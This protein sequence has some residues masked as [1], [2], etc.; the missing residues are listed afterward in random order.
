MSAALHDRRDLIFVMNSPRAEK[1]L[2]LS[3]DVGLI[4]FNASKSMV[5]LGVIF[6]VAVYKLNPLGLLRMVVRIFVY[7][8][9]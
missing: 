9:I 2:S 7:M 1:A 8:P 3:I 5:R 6:P 4:V